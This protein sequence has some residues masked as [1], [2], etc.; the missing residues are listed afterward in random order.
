MTPVFKRGETD[1]AALAP[2]AA[3]TAN[4]HPLLGVCTTNTPDALV[5]RTELSFDDHWIL[6]E[7]CLRAGDA[8]FPGTGY[9][10]LTLAAAGERFGAGAVEFEHLAF[11]APLRVGRGKRRSIEL[12]LKRAGDGYDF[13]VA[14]AGSPAMICATG[15]LRSLG[16]AAPNPIGALIAQSNQRALSFGPDTQNPKQAKHIDFGPRWRCLRRIHFGAGQ[17]VS[18]LE[19]A[20]EYAAE[21]ATYRLH[22]ALLDAATGSAMYTIPD[23]DQTED[24]YVP[25]AYR[26]LRLFADLPRRCW[27]HIRWPQGASVEKEAA[28]FDITITDD[29]G[30][31]IAEIEEFMLRRLH[32][33]AILSVD[34]AARSTPAEANMTS[35]AGDAARATIAQAPAVRPI[36]AAPGAP[37]DQF[38]QALARWWEELL[39][40]DHVSVHDDFFAL[41]GHSLVAVRLLTKIEKEFKQ[42]VPLDAFFE[43]RTIEALADRLRNR[44]PGP[45]TTIIPLRDKGDGPA[46]FCVHSMGGDLATFRHLVQAL[47]PDVNFYGIQ[48]HPDRVD[49][50]FASSLERMAAYYVS[51]LLAFQPEGPYILGGASLGSTVALEM[52]R[53][54]EATG[55]KVELLIAIDGAPQNTGFETSRWNPL[56]YWK[57]LRNVP[58]W[59]IDDL[60]DNF[61]SEVFIP[62]VWRRAK[63]T[64]KRAASAL[65]GSQKGPV[66]ELEGFMNLPTYSEKQA[67]FMRTLYTSFKNYAPKPYHGRVLL[68]QSRTEP[69]THLFDVACVWRGVAT[70]LEVV[71][72]P[73]THVSLIQPPNVQAIAADLKQRL[74]PLRKANKP[75]ELS[76]QSV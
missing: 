69:L 12:R 7:H 59:I 16:S 8:L 44:N 68:Y 14:G 15:S 3:G 70:N 11:S 2:R 58:V 45:V 4:R 63:A 65:L 55:N 17:A 62:R 56:Y 23:Y 30:A 49:P 67:Q 51:E 10:E 1:T 27:C 34:A 50:G 40:L 13:T 25:V 37:R 57:L 64:V 18:E 43:D 52:A 41:G 75:V 33:T 61:S 71:R 66:Y 76:R 39:G 53:Q 29:R 48:A 9:I 35:A 31:V 19:L 46:I 38:E 20:S 22:P 47:G 28:R 36:P 74:A 26:R 21:L 73:G 6:N 5:Y 42:V 32:S 72:V 54:I 24:L 60:L